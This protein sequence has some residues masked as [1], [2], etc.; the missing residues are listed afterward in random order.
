MKH[1]KKKIKKNQIRIIIKLLPPLLP[2]TFMSIFYLSLPSP[3]ML[4]R[5]PFFL[6]FFFFGF[7]QMEK[8]TP[9]LLSLFLSL[10]VPSFHHRF[11]VL[12]P[13]AELNQLKRN[14]TKRII[15]LIIQQRKTEK[16][17]NDGRPKTHKEMKK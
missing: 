8:K 1:R 15:N 6:V 10:S 4:P 12:Q 9:P 14:A 16:E 17:K 5:P 7:L 13:A 3:G 11:T 2:L